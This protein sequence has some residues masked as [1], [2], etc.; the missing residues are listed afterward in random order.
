MRI[1][2]RRA[3]RI[4]LY[5][6]R[7]QK[8]MRFEFP[9]LPGNLKAFPGTRVKLEEAL[10]F[11]KDPR[12]FGS[13]TCLW[14]CPISKYQVG[15]TLSRQPGDYYRDTILFLTVVAPNIPS[16]PKIQYT[17]SNTDSAELISALQSELAK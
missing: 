6:R 4:R 14:Q 12:H 2:A 10:A 13:Y 15:F 3:G 5:S 1:L 9:M 8:Q 11:L 7:K 17:L 16:L